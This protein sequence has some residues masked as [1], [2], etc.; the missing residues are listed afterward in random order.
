MKFKCLECGG[1]FARWKYRYDSSP[2][3]ED[4]SVCPLCG[5]IEP[6]ATWIETEKEDNT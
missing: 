2:S 4:E 3:G 5:V 6:R 1:T